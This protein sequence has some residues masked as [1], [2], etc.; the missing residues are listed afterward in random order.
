VELFLEIV[1]LQLLEE[2]FAHIGEGLLPSRTSDFISYLFLDLNDNLLKKKFSLSFAL[3]LNSSEYNKTGLI[4][5]NL[6]DINVRK[7]GMVK[8]KNL[9]RGD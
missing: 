1:V 9:Q 4:W 2:L 5:T 6:N 7:K 3:F 8:K